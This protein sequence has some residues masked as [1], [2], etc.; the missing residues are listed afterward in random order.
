[1]RLEVRLEGRL[2][3]RLEGRLELLPVEMV[4][5]R[6]V[7]ARGEEMIMTT[8]GKQCEVWNNVIAC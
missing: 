2:E 7:S 8:P 4:E 3:L 6:R 1:M 5:S